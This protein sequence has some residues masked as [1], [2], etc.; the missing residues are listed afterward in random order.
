[1]F[2]GQLLWVSVRLTLAGALYAVVA[3]FFGAWTN[4][5]AVPVVLV[6]TLTGLACATPVMA[7]A[8]TTYDEGARFALVFRFVVMPM[9][10]FSGTFF[11]ISQLPIGLRWLAWISPLWHG[12]QLARGISVGGV[13]GWEMLGHLAFLLAMFTAGALA[14]RTYFYRRLVV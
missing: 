6:G 3:L 4:I 5:G 2:G 1:V 9:T 10:L 14:A 12:N 8:A 7:M 13:G 11:P